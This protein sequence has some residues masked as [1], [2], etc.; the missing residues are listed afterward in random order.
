M[1]VDKGTI[2]CSA[3]DTSFEV[4][5]DADGDGNVEWAPSGAPSCSA[6]SACSQ[7]ISELCDNG[8]GMGGSL[9]CPTGTICMGLVHQTPVYQCVASCDCSN[10][11][12]CDPGQFTGYQRSCGGTTDDFSSATVV[13]S[14]PCPD[15][16]QGCLPYGANSFCFGNEGCLSAPPI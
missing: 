2:R 7:C 3:D 16:D 8:D 5:R 9:V 12:T 14:S 4:C 11:G 15:A 6:G 10:C 1:L 13:C